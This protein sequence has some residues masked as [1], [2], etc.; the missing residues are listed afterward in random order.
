MLSRYEQFTTLTSII[1]LILSTAY[2][3]LASYVNQ[4][5]FLFILFYFSN[6]DLC[7]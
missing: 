3:V 6:C 5:Y 1:L 2:S 4:C 7:I